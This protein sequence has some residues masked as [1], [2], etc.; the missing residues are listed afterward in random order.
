M[1]DELELSI[2]LPCYNE[3]GNIPLIFTR[4]EGILGPKE[5]IEVILV[6]NGST[7]NSKEVMASELKKAKTKAIRIV[8][9]A[10]NQGYGYGIMQGV[11]A[12]KGEVIA[13]THADMQ[14][15]PQDVLDIFE[16]YKTDLLSHQCYAKGCRV[17]RSFFDTFFT[18]GMAQISSFLIGVKMDDINGQPKMFHRQFL[19]NLEKAPD[20]FSL[21]LYLM[22]KAHDIGLPLKTSE[23]SFA[24][25]MHGEAK[26]GGSLKGKVKLISRTLKYILK[27]RD[28]IKSGV[29]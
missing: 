16:K 24:D 12:A 17:K 9:V 10:V 26:G 4:L 25:R 22:Y 20:D 7:D 23:V 5:N 29:R 19:R 28:D 15:D 18:W 8:E 2:V 21:D 11:H 1:S 6:D 27:I 13:W 14:T 3:S